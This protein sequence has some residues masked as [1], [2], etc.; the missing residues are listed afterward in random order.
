MSSLIC[1]RPALGRFDSARPGKKGVGYVS[2]SLVFA[3]GLEQIT[4]AVY[5]YGFEAALEEMARWAVAVVEGLDVY[6]VDL[7]QAS[8]RKRRRNHERQVSS[9]VGAL[10]GGARAAASAR[11]RTAP[12]HRGGGRG[13]V[14]RRP[15]A[16]N[17]VSF[18]AFT[19][20]QLA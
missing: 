16:A 17:L 18:L 8:F 10:L 13:R 5:Q 14:H 1:Q 2:V 3:C 11:D 15:P 19:L 12:R 7:A 4:V 9:R 6:A 20:A